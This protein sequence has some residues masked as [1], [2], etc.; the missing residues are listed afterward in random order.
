MRITHEGNV[1]TSKGVFGS[2]SGDGALNLLSKGVTVLN[3]NDA[4]QIL[5][6]QVYNNT[7]N[8]TANLHIASNGVIYRATATSYTTEEVD[9]KLAVKD[10]LIEK[11]S[12]RLDK[13]EKKLKK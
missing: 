6:P 4:S 1:Y 7:N 9:K 5:L 2:K 10:K 3:V 8:V 13:L 12:D 11:L